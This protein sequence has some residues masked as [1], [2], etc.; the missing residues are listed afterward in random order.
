M[1]KITAKA[2]L[3]SLFIQGIIKKTVGEKKNP[4]KTF[5][6]LKDGV[7]ISKQRKMGI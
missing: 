4:N 2:M 7:F 5:S 1:Q 3:S 6:V